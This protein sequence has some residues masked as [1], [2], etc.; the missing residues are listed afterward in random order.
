[1]KVMWVK[2][3][4][5]VTDIWDKPK[6]ESSRLNQALF[7]Q[8]LRVDRQKNNHLLVYTEDNYSG[9]VNKNHVGM[10]DSECDNY[11][12]AKV[13]NPLIKVYHST[14]SGNPITTLSIGSVVYYEQGKSDRIKLIDPIGWTCKTNLM[15]RKPNKP[16]VSKIIATMKLFLGTPYLWGGKSGF[17][18]DCSGLVQLVYGI[19]GVDVPRDTKVQINCGKRVARKNMQKGDLIFSPGHVSVYMGAGKIIHSSLKASGVKIESIDKTS[20]LYRGDIV[21]KI[22]K[23]KRIL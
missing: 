14:A 11:L 6:F 22:T 23:I 13:K 4:V 2:V 21:D 7:G 17:G 15:I 18:I 8:I 12:C 5:P 3:N 10:L 9:W 20:S 19:F 16:S 1:M